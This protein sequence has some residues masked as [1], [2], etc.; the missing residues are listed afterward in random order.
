MCRHGRP[1]ARKSDRKKK[2]LLSWRA[3]IVLLAWPCTALGAQSAS[4][5]GSDAESPVRT[6]LLSLGISA[7]YSS[8][9]VDPGGLLEPGYGASIVAGWRLPFLPVVSLRMGMEY[10]YATTLGSPTLSFIT[11]GSGL[12]LHI[13]R[14]P[15]VG[16]NAFAEA[17]YSYA[18]I[19]DPGVSTGY[20]ILQLKAGLDAQLF[21]SPGFSLTAGLWYGQELGLYGG[22]ALS[23][24]TAIE[25][26]GTTAGSAA[27]TVG[28]ALAE[29]RFVHD[30][31]ATAPDAGEGSTAGPGKE[32]PGLAIEKL[33]IPPVFPVFYKYY[34]LNPLGSL[35]L[36]NSTGADLTDVSVS[37]FIRNYMG[38]AQTMKP[39]FTL[40]QGESRDVTLHA[41]FSDQILAVTERTKVQAEITVRYT[42]GGAT[43]ELVDVESL[44]ILDRNAMTWAD[45][46]GA[47]AFVTPKDTPVMTFAKGAAGAIKGRGSRAVNANLSLAMALHEALGAYGVAYVVDPRSA[48]ADFS[49][50]GA[51]VDYLQFPRQTLMWKSGDCDDLS[52]LDCAL[53][54]AVGID[55]A[56]ITVP[57]HIFIAFSL[58]IGPDQARALFSRVD[59]LIF[60]D[61]QAW[62]PV[63]VTAVG[64]GFLEAWAL[65]AREWRE[66]S[67]LDMAGFYPLREAWAIYDS[68]FFKGEDV[69]VTLPSDDR[70][71]PAFLREQAAFIDRETAE[72]A[73]RLK[74]EIKKSGEDPKAVNRLGALY[75]KFGLYDKAAKEFQRIVAK[76]EYGPAL[77]NLGTIAYAQGSLD[78]ALAWYRRA[79]KVE[80]GASTVLLGLAR[81]YHDREN[82]DEVR[83]WY[84]RLAEVDPQLAER[85][86]YLGLRGEQTT[87]SADMRVAEELA[88]AE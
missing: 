13:L 46:R 61:D 70:F 7:V 8:P 10:L 36:T 18:F 88:W 33:D 41:L 49:A 27:P 23:L 81:V 16:L 79:Y 71:L 24:G 42:A 65:G 62:V 50:R 45:N 28:R 55:T 60:R 82:Y 22:L 52:I 67:A 44:A 85:Y 59:D 14:T 63:E 72:Q 39:S 57:G 1:R 69:Q 68:V 31:P 25:L 17:G 87:R 11:A 78:A 43:R 3:A 2:A 47:A 58:G 20:G 5:S 75:A 26:G 29:P 34:D 86:A 74:A 84:G 6:T 35:R 73:A 21:L 48:Y 64:R 51:E 12:G 77:C 32:A 76:T 83:T 80:P 66:A 56:F 15:T 40:A 30:A 53:L 54:A 37:V 9:V 19:N 38:A 4:P